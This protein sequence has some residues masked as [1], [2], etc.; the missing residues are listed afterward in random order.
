MS[1]R[2]LFALT[3]IIAFSAASHAQVVASKDPDSLAI[4]KIFDEALL[5]GQSYDNLHYMCKKIGHRLSG[6][7]QAAA[8][9]EY[10]YQVMQQFCDT[11]YLQECMV[12][13]WVRGTHD[14]GK[15]TGSKSHGTVPVN[16]LA[17][18]GSIATPAGGVTAEVLEVHDFK[19]L[20][21]LGKKGV[22]GKI[23]FFNHPFDNAHVNTFHA[24]GECVEYRWA[25]PSVAAKYGAAATIVR[26]MTNGIDE[27]PHTG[28]MHYDTL[29]PKVPCAAICTRDAELLSKI[30]KNEGKASF[31][32]NL[33]CQT[34]PDVKSYNVI[35][36]LRGSERPEEII[37]VGGHLD[38]WDV[39]E[40][41]HDDG[42]GVVQ[43]ME[44]LR[45][46]K[47]T[48]VRPKHTLRAIMFMNEE[49]G[50]RGGTK[51]AEVVAL[52]KEKHIAALETDAGGFS[53]RGFG[54][55]M[56][57][58]QQT[59]VRTWAP[60]LLPYGIHEL[61]SGG[62]GADIGPLAKQGVPVIG[63]RPDSQRYF[64]YHHTPADVFEAVNKRELEMGGAA[65]AALL[66][67][68]DMY[69]L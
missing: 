65:I 57:D 48:G 3:G 38:S 31:Y 24:Y 59:K 21:K 56:T 49:N 5:H 10:T 52:K 1:K 51:Y 30:I 60:L 12:P 11:V 32:L 50:L 62:G 69:G 40:G 34:L 55:G 17:L 6:S 66:Y 19:E 39:G 43:S 45:L 4:R 64:N 35:G 54:L 20:E 18:G 14:E 44:V 53:P 22:Q 29:Q 13:H 16:L 63:L 67:L 27:F 68:I 28:S 41:A 26:S 8:A 61:K 47:A 15:I 37:A 33:D 46:F 25:G 36:E 7:P 42:A 58:A 2:L 9:V 23:V